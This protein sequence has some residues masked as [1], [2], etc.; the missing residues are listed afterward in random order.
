MINRSFYNQSGEF[1]LSFAL[2][3]TLV[4]GVGVKV[5]MDRLT[6]ESS[7][8]TQGKQ[9]DA[10]GNAINAAV[11]RA[12]ALLKP[13]RIVPSVTLGDLK[14]EPNAYP[15]NTSSTFQLIQNT[16]NVVDWEL[17]DASTLNITLPGMGGVGLT[18]DQL[19][20][21]KFKNP[22]IKPSPLDPTLLI[23]RGFDVDASAT[24][25]TKDGQS[26]QITRA[27]I[28]NVD[29]CATGGC[30]QRNQTTECELIGPSATVEPNVSANA[31]LR[32]KG[33]ALMANVPRTATELGTQ[34]VAQGKTL[35]FNGKTYSIAAGDNIFLTRFVDAMSDIIPED[36]RND[37]ILD[38]PPIDQ[39]DNWR[40]YNIKFTT[41]RPLSAVDGGTVTFPMW[42]SIKLSD[43]SWKGCSVGSVKISQVTSCEFLAPSSP[44]IDNSQPNLE[45]SESEYNSFAGTLVK[46]GYDVPGCANTCSTHSTQGTCSNDNNC[47]WFKRLPTENGL[48]YYKDTK[49]FIACERPSPVDG[50]YTLVKKET[51]IPSSA[52]ITWRVGQGGAAC[53]DM[54]AFVLPPPGYFVRNSAGD[55]VSANSLPPNGQ[56]H[57]SANAI[58]KL[59]DAN[60]RY[61]GEM[62]RLTSTPSCSKKTFEIAAP[63]H[64][65]P[66]GIYRIYGNYKSGQGNGTCMVSITS[67]A[68]PCKYTNNQRS[69]KDI[70]FYINYYGNQW[71]T[72]PTQMKPTSLPE[73]E[74]YADSPTD[75]IDCATRDMRCFYTNNL[76]GGNLG[77]RTLFVHLDKPGLP[78]CNLVSV[79]RINLGCFAY[80]S[81]ILMADGSLQD[82][83]LV[84]K[85]QYVWNPVAKMA[86]RVVETTNGPEKPAL[87]KISTSTGKSISVTQ[88]HPVLT[89][90]GLKPAKT[91]RLGDKVKEISGK[92]EVITH[93]SNVKPEGSFVW[94]VRL[95]GDSK[96]EAMHY[97]LV[98]G[99]ITG[100]LTLQEQLETK[101]RLSQNGQN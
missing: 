81:K 60:G 38:D 21:L 97:V 9:V 48:C 23:L 59:Y 94:N 42:S 101:L 33:R 34:I 96:D 95:E 70:S 20:T 85:D 55:L 74:Y 73:S 32:I 87:I 29:I 14:V 18:A 84:N 11:A 65:I 92:S 71:T 2:I 40:E 1:S 91:L 58:T 99:M 57:N 79:S 19:V 45:I 3:L 67:G 61:V 66:R 63:S 10:V 76:G 86:S 24:F 41:P 54:Q 28:V 26:Q 88:N 36:E 64:F 69:S 22:I 80:G 35:V 90:S 82:G 68:D 17:K 83:E 31:T 4:A 93:I 78:T 12:E 49:K 100:D 39:R 53:Q 89:D 25:L 75:V 16:T 44:E 8:V 50:N 47:F 15:I 46:K 6:T 77:N 43:G 98:D 51:N 37:I 72:P 5:A 62:P 30:G 27:K 13:R 56:W 52:Q 7:S